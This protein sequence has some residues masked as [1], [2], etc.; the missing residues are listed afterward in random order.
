MVSLYPKEYKGEVLRVEDYKKNIL[1]DQWLK[2][3]KDISWGIYLQSYPMFVLW[4]QVV[5]WRP[6]DVLQENWFLKDWGI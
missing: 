3:A 4:F 1:D 5:I 2:Y 6:G